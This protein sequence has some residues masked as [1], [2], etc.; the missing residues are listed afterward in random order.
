MAPSCVL[1]NPVPPRAPH[2]AECLFRR[3]Q[4]AGTPLFICRESLSHFPE[5][6][7]RL[8]K[9]CSRRSWRFELVW[10]GCGTRTHILGFGDRCS[11]QLNYHRIWRKKWDSNPRKVAL[12][13]LSKM[14][15][16]A[17]RPFFHKVL[18]ILVPVKRTDNP[19][20]IS[21]LGAIYHPN[22]IRDLT[23]AVIARFRLCS[24]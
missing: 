13:H 2:R 19:S 10:H 18:C 11:N 4:D 16:S 15:P 3:L 24:N 8:A 9:F 17:S 1:F 20:G 23:C 22:D 12:H 14:A 6:K 5:R 21:A 7:Q